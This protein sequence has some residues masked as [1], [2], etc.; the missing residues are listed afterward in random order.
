[1]TTQILNGISFPMKEEFDFSF[2]SRWGRVFK[3]FPNQDSGNICFGTEKNGER[4]FLKFAGAP[5][6]R[7]E[8]DPAD[9][10]AN[11]KKLPE[12]ISLCGIRCSLS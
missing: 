3:V 7:Y 10:V 8:G 5:T 4:F 1:M 6:A 9:A 2:V 11:L 12:I